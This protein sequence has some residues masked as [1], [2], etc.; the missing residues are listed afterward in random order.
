MLPPANGTF[1][2]RKAG[3]A[4][5]DPDLL[6]ARSYDYSSYN[7]LAP[8]IYRLGVYKAGNTV[9]AFKTIA[10]DLRADTYFTVLLS[11]ASG[12]MNIEVVDDTITRSQNSRTLTIRNYFPGARVQA[13]ALDEKL[14]D[15]LAYGQ[16]YTRSGFSKAR[17]K[18]H[19]SVTLANGL[20]IET[21]IEPDFLPSTRATILIIPDSYDRLAPIVTFDGKNL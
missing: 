9:T 4:S 7:G 17:I 1:S 14:D 16:S 6:T 3:S 12:R 13:T 15:V 20:P 11:P 8:G 2:L 19:L 18:I 10:I 21:S 5:S